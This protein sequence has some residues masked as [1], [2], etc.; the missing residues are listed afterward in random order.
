MHATQTSMRVV[1]DWC[2]ISRREKFGRWSSHPLISCS[3][4]SYQ[5][6]LVEKRSHDIEIKQSMH[7][8]NFVA[9]TLFLGSSYNYSFYGNSPRQSS[10]PWGAEWLV[11]G[12]PIKTGWTSPGGWY[13][14]AMWGWGGVSRWVESLCMYMYARYMI[15]YSID[16]DMLQVVTAWSLKSNFCTM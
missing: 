13:W 6:W 9:F 10:L 4:H 1:M 12:F 5:L 2:C 3:R 7:L 15:V 11:E 8:D 16:H 14:A